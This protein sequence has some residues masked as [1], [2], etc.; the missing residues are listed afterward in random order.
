MVARRRDGYGRIG[1]AQRIAI[2]TVSIRNSETPLPTRKQLLLNGDMK[3]SI[4]TLRAL[5]TLEV[6]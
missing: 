5:R 1:A 3:D 6:C 2:I 4:Y